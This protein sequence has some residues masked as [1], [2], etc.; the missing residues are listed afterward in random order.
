MQRKYLEESALDGWLAAAGERFAV[1]APRKGE[2]SIEFA[3]YVAGSTEIRLTSPGS[4]WPVKRF[5]FPQSES[6]LRYNFQASGRDRVQ[7]VAP[8]EQPVLLFG[9]RP[10]DAH[11]FETLDAVFLNQ[12]GVV[13]P[14]YKVRRDATTVITVACDRPARTCF[15]AS[16]EGNPH[17][18]RGADALLRDAGDGYVVEIVT[19]KGRA[20]LE[21]APL[22]EIDAASD[23]AVETVEANKAAAEEKASIGVEPREFVA[24]LEGLFESDVWDQIH[25]KCIA[26]GA[27]TFLCPT[28]HCFDIQDE[29]SGDDGRRLR[30]WDSCQFASFTL[31]ASGHNP[32]TTQRERWRQRAM[33][34]LCWYPGKF[35]PLGCVGCG[36][37]VRDCPTGVDIRQIIK[38]LEEATAAHV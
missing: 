26:C 11:S 38:T 31:H 9:V 13:D 7:A 8:E 19:D 10:C 1:F 33:H 30:N 27:C 23:G 35:G 37:C 21:G 14:Y 32:R 12:D 36:R 5:L 34:K 24:A 6:L 17:G 2:R 16:M 29:Q 3:P 18:S 15:C 25:E 28:C 22:V 20:A 4:K